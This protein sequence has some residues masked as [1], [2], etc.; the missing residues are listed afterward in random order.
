MSSCDVIV[1]LMIRSRKIVKRQ[2]FSDANG[3]FVANKVKSVITCDEWVDL[4]QFCEFCE[5]PMDS[6]STYLLYGIIL[7]TGESL[8][9][10]HFTSYIRNVFNGIAEDK[11]YYFNDNE[12]VQT[13]TNL[14]SIREKEKA[15]V[16]FYRRM[17]KPLP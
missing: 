15:Y 6:T 3:E 16:L 1:V 13:F 8:H 9:N 7:H 10:G 17:E 2:K 12:Q 4:S 14:K 5:G 11:W